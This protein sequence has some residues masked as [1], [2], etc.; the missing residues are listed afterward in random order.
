MESLIATAVGQGAPTEKS[1][2]LSAHKVRQLCYY[3]LRNCVSTAAK[4]KETH[5]GENTDLSSSTK[6]SAGG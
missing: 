2:S 5:T 6:S 1:K 4:Q 3:C